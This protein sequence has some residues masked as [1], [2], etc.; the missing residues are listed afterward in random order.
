MCDENGILIDD[1]V[2]LRL[3]PDHFMWVVNVTKTNEDFRWVLGHSPGLDFQVTNVRAV[4]F[5][6]GDACRITSL[7]DSAHLREH[8]AIRR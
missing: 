8:D 1:L 2:C 5:H 4:H 6:R 7:S 3:A